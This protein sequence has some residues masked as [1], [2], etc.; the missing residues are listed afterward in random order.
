VSCG[1]IQT[2]YI[3]EKSSV[4]QPEVKGEGVKTQRNK[5]KYSQNAFP[6]SHDHKGLLI[7]VGK[8]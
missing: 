1:G 6:R 2:G 7:G 5:L 4:D 8:Y 3:V